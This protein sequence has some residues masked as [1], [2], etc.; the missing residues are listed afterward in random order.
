MRVEVAKMLVALA[1]A[2]SLSAEVAAQAPKPDA[3]FC[4]R[5]KGS[6]GSAEHLGCE[7]KTPPNAFTPEIICINSTTGSEYKLKS[8][9]AYDE[10]ANGKDGCNPCRPEIVPGVH[11]EHPRGEEGQTK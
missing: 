9:A 5:R 1:M 6:E 3:C 10:I 7:R 11:A 2:G 8:L 4:L